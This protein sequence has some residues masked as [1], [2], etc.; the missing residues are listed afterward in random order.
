MPR[1]EINIST[2]PFRNDRLYFGLVGLFCFGLF[3]LTAFN[4][5]RLLDNRLAARRI[6]KEIRLTEA[7]TARIR[8]LLDDPE[9]RFSRGQEKEASVYAGFINGIIARRNF[10]WTL[11]FNEL[12]RVTPHGV[13]VS[14]VSPTFREDRVNLVMNCVGKDLEKDVLAFIQL[15]DESPSFANAFMGGET[16]EA[17]G[18]YQFPL[19]VD[20]YPQVAMA[21]ILEASREPKPPGEP[22]EGVNQ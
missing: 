3:L 13:R 6:E 7:E 17:G 20:Y 11:L 16:K 5:W 8:A 4:F 21:Q 14:S 10:S 19:M 2:R 18:T 22:P 15:L 1:L 9:R 12:E